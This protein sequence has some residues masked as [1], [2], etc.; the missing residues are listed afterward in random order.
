MDS[1]PFAVYRTAQVDLTPIIE[2]LGKGIT[3][4]P[5][6]HLK[7]L[8]TT[9]NAR[10]D[11]DHAWFWH[12][13]QD[14]FIHRQPTDIIQHHRKQ[15]DVNQSYLVIV[16]EE[17]VDVTGLL[18]VNLNFS[19]TVDA[20]REKT[21]RV[22]D[23]VPSLDVGNSSWVDH[24]LQASQPL[25]PR[26]AFAVFVFP[27]LNPRYLMK[28]ITDKINRGLHGRK[29]STGSVV[30]EWENV[31]GDIDETVTYFKKHQTERD[32]NSDYFVIVS[33]ESWAREEVTLVCMGKDGISELLPQKVDF[34]GE[35][36]SW[37][38]TGLITVAE[39]K[40]ND[41]LHEVLQ[42]RAV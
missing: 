36:L 34:A 11:Q 32:W 14:S 37:L 31:S 35:A 22:G 1:R 28:E 6:A 15:D 19:S 10:I 42:S 23:F 24:L 38:Y 5:I 12:R 7:M 40:D 41:T 18:V 4:G 2:R 39:L 25:Y 13:G 16:D 3:G 9:A 8:R 17:D 21:Y 33:G 26:K 30:A 27:D 29:A 20:V